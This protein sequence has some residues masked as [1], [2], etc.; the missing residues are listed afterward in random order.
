MRHLSPGV[1]LVA[2]VAVLLAAALLTE[3][4]PGTRA[5]E[6][7]TLAVDADPEG[8][9]NTSPGQ[10]QPCISV[11]PGKTFD[12]DVLI[13]NVEDLIGWEA[14]FRYDEDILEVVDAHDDL[15]QAANNPGG[16][17]IASASDYAPDRDGVFFLGAADI[18]Q[19]LDSGSGVLARLTLRAIGSGVSPADLPALDYDGDAVPDLG[20]TIS[21]L[22]FDTIHHPGDINGDELFDGPTY[23][24]QIAVGQ[25]C[26]VTT[27]APTLPET[28]SPAPGE[29]PGP[30]STPGPGQ[31][32]GPGDTPGPDE[33]PISEGT[34]GPSPADTGPGTTSG[35]GSG[36]SQPSDGGLPLW[37]IGPIAAAAVVFAVG[38]LGVW[39]ALRHA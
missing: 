16:G 39:R 18:N 14:A 3:G 8:N 12:V 34:P 17:G 36:I 32:A 33:T 9:T 11:D 21:T 27:P 15:F 37:I 6:P 2:A 28:A 22:I 1:L 4:G 25:P 23:H 24:A 38:M 26:P 20:P 5:R 10:V 31:T 30:D 29:T 7:L 13:M 35:D 19:L